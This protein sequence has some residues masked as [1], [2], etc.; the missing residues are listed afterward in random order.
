M[1]V[2][3]VAAVA[4]AAPAAAIAGAAD[5]PVKRRRGRPRKTELPAA[6]GGADAS[7]PQKAGADPT[8]PKKQRKRK[9]D[10]A[11]PSSVDVS[12]IGQQVTGVLDGTFD[13]GYLL[14]VRVGTSDM[15]LRGVVFGPGL[16]VPI[17]RA[18]DVAPGVKHVR[19]EERPLPAAPK[20]PI[21]AKPPAAAKLPIV[22]PP[23]PFTGSS[24]LPPA[25]QIP[26]TQAVLE[27][28][29]ALFT[30]SV[31]ATPHPPPAPQPTGLVAALQQLPGGGYT[32][33]VATF[34]QSTFR[35]I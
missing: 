23:R 26:P 8:K 22:P 1:E 25:S 20:L 11:A 5:P 16:S 12:M 32:P 33:D 2:E 35:P 17:S 9:G 14:T 3:P 4:A 15:I 7:T 34:S 24:P 19:R 28:A 13:A 6:A 30:N 21:S 31:T 27:S 29:A 18:N 10:A